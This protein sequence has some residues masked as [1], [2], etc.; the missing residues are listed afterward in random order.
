MLPQGVDVNFVILLMFG[1]NKVI[2][3]KRIK[4]ILEQLKPNDL[5]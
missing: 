1:N 3:T 4:K 5:E 2:S